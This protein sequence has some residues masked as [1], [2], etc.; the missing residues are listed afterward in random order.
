MSPTQETGRVPIMDVTGLDG[1]PAGGFEQTV[2]DQLYEGVY[3]VDPARRIRYWNPGAERLSGWKAADVVGR[4]CHDN[5]LNHVD[6]SGKPLCRTRCPLAASMQDGRGREA[7][8]FLRHRLGHRVQVRVR[9]SAVRERDGRTVGGVE[10]FDDKTELSAARRHL[11]ELR[12]L[13]MTD[14]LTGVPNRRHFEMALRSRVAEFAG[15]NRPFGLLIADLD[16]FKVL[17]D[18]HGHATGDLALRTVARTMLEASRASDDLARIGGEEFGITVPDV[19]ASQLR[20]IADRMCSL[21]ERTTV[22]A[23]GRDLAV[24]VSIGGATA[25]AGDTPAMLFER[26]DRALYVAKEEG[27]NRVVIL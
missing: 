1:G 26:A 14:Q 4:F 8:V 9:T 25:V 23:G 19:N 11:S 21:V 5:I 13:A 22:R 6:D 18:T 16:R 3:F 7:D 12:D 15:Y 10:I 20:S 24:T 27:R 2:M 17:N